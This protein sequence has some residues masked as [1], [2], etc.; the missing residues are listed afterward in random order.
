MAKLLTGL[1]TGTI[2]RMVRW[3]VLPVTGVIPFLVSSGIL[4]LTYGAIWLAFGAALV[5]DPAALD[6]AWSWIVALPLPLQ[7]L[8]WLLFLPVMAGLWVWTTSWALAVRVALV[9]G[10]AT[11]NVIVFIPRKAT[12][13]PALAN[14]PEA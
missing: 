5:S 14:N 2:D 8:G 6:R 3:V 12:V 1:L 4:L 9:L 10:L 11:W 13:A 7:G